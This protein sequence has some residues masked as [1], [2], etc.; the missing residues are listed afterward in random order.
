MSVYDRLFE[1]ERKMVFPNDW[2]TSGAPA[3]AL[4]ILHDETAAGYPVGLAHD[5]E[6]GWIVLGCGQGPFI[7][8]SEHDISR[9]AR[10]QVN[11]FL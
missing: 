7:C 3:E 6:A 4:K 8:W 9:H 11:P 10:S 5:H 1:L 2:N